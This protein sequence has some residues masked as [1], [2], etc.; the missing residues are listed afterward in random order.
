MGLFT[1]IK[2]LGRR[3]FNTPLSFDEWLT[4]PPPKTAAAINRHLDREIARRRGSNPS[5]PGSKP[6]APA[7]MPSDEL[8][9]RWREECRQLSSDSDYAIPASS[10]MAERVVAWARQQQAES[11]QLSPPGADPVATDEELLR[12]ARSPVWF[13]EARRALYNRGRLDERAAIAKELGVEL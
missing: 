13:D 9:S 10:F 8:M 4:P 7:E 3:G 5:A 11:F 12:V 2:G 1:W 6:A